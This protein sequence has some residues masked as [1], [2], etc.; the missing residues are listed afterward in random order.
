MDG[1][2]TDFRLALR[3]FLKN[4]AF[5]AIAVVTLALGIGANTAIFTLLDQVMLRMLPVERPERLVV[6]N[7]P[8]PFSGWTNR[9]S[10]TITPVSHPMYLGL[11]RL[12]TV[13]EESSPTSRPR[14]T[15][16]SEETDL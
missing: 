7:A 16:Q 3:S 6:L 8:G 2:W 5:A 1:L 15:C 10:D 9:N 14:S 11:R 4:P 13:F 12:A